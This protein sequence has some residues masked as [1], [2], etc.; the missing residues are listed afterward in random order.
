[1][2]A[3]DPISESSTAVD[4]LIVRALQGVVSEAEERLLAAWRN[5]SPANERYFRETERFWASGAGLRRASEQRRTPTVHELTWPVQAAVRH[6]SRPSAQRPPRWRRRVGIAALVLLGLF[7]AGHV[8]LRK[9]SDSVPGAGTE[10]VAGAAETRTVTL[11][12]GTIVLLTPGSRLRAAGGGVSDV[13]L[14]GRAYFSVPPRAA[15]QQFRVQ[16]H[17][18]VAMVLGT[19]FDLDTR[20]DQMRLLVVEGEVKLAA[21]GHEIEVT[22]NQIARLRGT[23]EMVSERVDTS[24]VQHELR[25]MRD[26]LVFTET[27]LDQVAR[28]LTRYYG[29]PVEL[30]DPSL[31]GQTVHA[32]FANEELDDVLP[33][34]CRAVEARCEIGADRVTI[35]SGGGQP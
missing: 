27:P 22:A 15:G 1:M 32:W 12:D 16:T 23:G 6:R 4:E 19:R 13:W 21:R 29:V 8:L 26:F 10:L 14:E 30:L 35:T 9:F 17:A 28:E 25:W 18:G 11:S 20:N 5:A 34:I 33:V 3:D 2:A 7:G 24:Y 31:A